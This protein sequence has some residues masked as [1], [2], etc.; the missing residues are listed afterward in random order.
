MALVPYKKRPAIE[1]PDETSAR[2]HTKYKETKRSDKTYGWDQSRTKER[3][4]DITRQGHPPK[5]RAAS[6]S[7]EW[8][9]PH[10]HLVIQYDDEIE[11]EGA[12]TFSKGWEKDKDV[13]LVQKSND[14]KGTV[15]VTTSDAFRLAAA[16]PREVDLP[17][18]LR[19]H[20]YTYMDPHRESRIREADKLSV[21]GLL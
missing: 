3:G 1:D 16:K 15:D 13:I 12:T 14:V 6:I 11:R 2:T 21:Y 9:R 19:E 5:K 10:D 20:I 17:A 18:E 4:Y 8:G 7:Y